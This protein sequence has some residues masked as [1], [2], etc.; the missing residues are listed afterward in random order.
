M[1]GY[2]DTKAMI[3]STL[4]GRPAGTEIQP[5]NQQ[6]YEL[7][8]LDY[9]RSLE[10]ISSSS[11][12]GVADESTTPVQPDNARVSYIAGVAQN[13]TVTFQNFIGQNGQPLSIT[14]SDMEAYLVIL[15]WN[16]QYWTM[17]AI[18]TNIISSAETAYF[19][20]NYN[21][22][23][24]YTSVSA[25][26]AD[27]VNPIGVDGK[28]IKV[29]DLVSIVNSNNSSENGMYSY[30][31]SE[32]QFQTSYNFQLV[33]S[34]GNDPNVGVSQQGL[35]KVINRSNVVN[36]SSINWVSGSY[37]NTTGG[38]TNNSTFSHSENYIDISGAISIDITSI[39][40]TNAC[41]AFY[42]E[43]QTFI[44]NIQE[45]SGNDTTVIRKSYGV[46]F[47]AKYIRISCLT[48]FK[49]YCILSFTSNSDLKS[50]GNIKAAFAIPRINFTK[51]SPLKWDDLIT[52]NNSTGTVT[53]NTP[54]VVFGL[55]YNNSN[56]I[57]FDN[58]QIQFDITKEW[59][60]ACVRVPANW[61]SGT[62]QAV[63]L[64]TAD[65]EL[66]YYGDA[67]ELTPDRIPLW[68]WNKN[69]GNLFSPYFS[70]LMITENYPSLVTTVSGLN[71]QFV[72]LS[73]YFN[74]AFEIKQEPQYDGIFVK[75]GV[76]YWTAAVGS[77][78]AINPAASYYYM[79]IMDVTPGQRLRLSG[80]YTPQSG[81]GICAYIDANGNYL[82]RLSS[83]ANFATGEYDVKIPDNVYKIGI[84]FNNT[85]GSAWPVE[86][87]K[88]ILGD[89]SIK[90]LAEALPEGLEDLANIPTRV[91]DLENVEDFCYDVKQQKV[92]DYELYG[93]GVW[94]STGQV[95]GQPV[96]LSASENYD[97]QPLIS[98][99][100]GDYVN[101]KGVYSASSGVGCFALIDANG[102]YLGRK[103]FGNAIESDSVLGNYKFLIDNAA[104]V[105]IGWYIDNRQSETF[106][107]A[108]AKIILNEGDLTLSLTDEY[109]TVLE[110]SLKLNPE[111]EMDLVAQMYNRGATNKKANTKK[112]CILIWGQSNA[113]GRDALADAPQYIK[114]L[115]YILPKAQLCN[116][117]A[118]TFAVWNQTT[119]WAFKLITAY[120]LTEVDNEECYFINL[121]VG[122]TSMA[123]TG[124]TTQHWTP[125]FDKLAST[126][127]SLLR[128]LEDRTRN[129]LKALSDEFEI[130][131]IIG[132][133]G[134]GDKDAVSAAQY[135]KNLICFISYLRGVV[136]NP[137]LPFVSGTIPHLSSSY[138]KVVEEAQLQA[139]R[140]D[141]Y[142]YYVD[143][144]QGTMFDG[145]H[146]DAATSEYFGISV[147]NK[148]KEY[149]AL[150]ALR[151]L[152]NDKPVL[153]N[154]SGQIKVGY[155]GL[156]RTNFVNGT[157][158]ALPFNTAVAT[159][160]PSPLTKYPYGSVKS[161]AA[162]YSSSS[163][164]LREN[165]VYGQV[166][167]WRI[168]A[169]YS[170]KASANN[171][172]LEFRLNNTV[173]GFIVTS[174]ITLPSGL[175]EGNIT[176]ELT[177][178][179]D[180]NSLSGTNGYVLEVISSFTDANLV[181]NVTS[182]TR[183]SEATENVS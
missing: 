154:N 119:A 44:S 14:T 136:G 101:V 177:T 169:T 58:F 110:E 148:L 12:I 113:D 47:R 143:L 38:T 131:G 99:K 124:T 111:S 2:N 50:I 109:K 165:N 33:Q 8:M 56:Y 86:N 146:F 123:E 41:L 53:F 74:S 97:A 122:G 34:L 19:Y 108:N 142:T 55:P 118:G 106:P 69:T 54:S 88:I 39:F 162:M 20:Y 4:M 64:N 155:T 80:F 35:T 127:T 90:L 166:H 51:R 183:I 59:G 102:N 135:H 141:Y 93:K 18:P 32:W 62:N 107:P 87:A 83:G 3:I 78:I 163:R 63:L 159:V 96:L 181:V 6:A 170:G 48:S 152:Y 82:S 180:S 65:V 167:R 7:N 11:I 29:G 81:I 140:E 73:G 1:A 67:W 145:L 137:Y 40:Y 91:A 45:S 129:A 21:I 77:P 125:F 95:V 10:L 179:A 57:R 121:T 116:N 79:N 26:N 153:Q 61:L 27:S 28:P 168:Q 66:H 139:M 76:G 49:D 156:S 138:N 128:N 178:I 94:Q 182:I 100:Q 172:Q 174:E 112:K 176:C 173:S 68:F 23:K 144:S 117:A 120:Y 151:K 149:F 84:Y 85:G 24:T 22:R 161:Y 175:T 71:A 42:D 70:L 92:Y 75:A 15:L 171:G 60:V 104:T 133:Q 36:P 9:I 150:A 157:V 164:K 160:A 147:Y 130:V 89:Y 30:T 5:E 25:M 115:N 158:Y 114:D 52:V 17:Q 13:R 46:P 134:E 132:H 16:A 43:N 98:V 103:N 37:I 126:D 31:G 105:K 72:K